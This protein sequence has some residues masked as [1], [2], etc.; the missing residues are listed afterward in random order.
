MTRCDSMTK[1]VEEA[2]QPIFE[3][4]GMGWF[5]AKVARNMAQ[6]VASHYNIVP[7]HKIVV[8]GDEQLK[9]G[10]TIPRAARLDPFGVATSTPGGQL[11]VMKHHVPRATTAHEMTHWVMFET[12]TGECNPITHEGHCQHFMRREIEVFRILWPGAQYGDWLEAAFAPL[13][14]R[15]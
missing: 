3:R 15:T 11:T 13:L 9:G 4:M 6:R 7:P 2:E 10:W 5:S 14:A 12:D 1:Q 8:F